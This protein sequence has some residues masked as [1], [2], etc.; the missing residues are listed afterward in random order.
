MS[1]V[2]C[3]YCGLPFRVRRVEPGRDYFCCTGCSILAR[4]PVDAGGNYPV[5]GALVSGLTLGFLYF[6]Q[7]LAWLVGVL[8]AREGKGL[9]ADRFAWVS[10][11]AA[12]VVWAAVLVL[13]RRGGVSRGKDY[14][15]AAL[16]L[17]LLV[18]S[19][20][21]LPPSGA[22]CAAANAV[23][24]VWNFRGAARRRRADGPKD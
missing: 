19:A 6:N 18:A 1:T 5:N 4:V 22:L 21:T 24:L 8:L 3:R 12:L 7:V 15:V 16:V 10:A 17:G 2:T 14:V 13:Q 20:R 9:L 11:G 23:L